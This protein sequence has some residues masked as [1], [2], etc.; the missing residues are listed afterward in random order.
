MRRRRLVVAVGRVYDVVDQSWVGMVCALSS[1]EKLHERLE[2]K[3]AADNIQYS[4]NRGERL[5]N[6]SRSGAICRD[7]RQRFRLSFSE[8]KRIASGCCPRWYLRY[9]VVHLPKHCESQSRR[10]RLSFTSKSSSASAL[11]SSSNSSLASSPS[12]SLLSWASKRCLESLC[13]PSS[14]GVRTTLWL[15]GSGWS[16]RTFSF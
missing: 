1:L 14:L 10:G 16:G 6:S 11:S 13:S 2:V 8:T 3:C 9:L 7:P 12:S 4:N 15:V 5:S